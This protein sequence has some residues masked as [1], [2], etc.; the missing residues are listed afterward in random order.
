MR[1]RAKGQWRRSPPKKSPEVKPAPRAGL[2]ARQLAVRLVT[3]VIEDGRPLDQ[4]WSD[5]TRS[6]QFSALEPRDR[7]FARMLTATTL[8]RQGELEFVLKQFLERPLPDDKGHLWP[9]LLVGA[10]QLVCL[11]L[12]PHAVVDLGVELTRLDRGARRFAKLTNAV[13]RRVSEKGTALL[14][15][16]D[17]MHLNVPEWLLSRWEQTYGP[18]TARQIAQSS[19]REAPLDLSVKES[20][21]T[22]AWAERLGATALPMGSLRLAEHTGRIEDLPGYTEGAWWVQDAAAALVSRAAGAVAGLSVADLCAAP[23]GKTASLA[24]AGAHVTAVDASRTRLA[25]LEENMRRLGLSVEVVCADVAQWSPDREFDVVLLDA[26]CSATGTIRRHPDLMRQKQTQ[27]ITRLAQLQAAL[28]ARAATYV[29]PGGILLYSTCSLEPEEGPDQIEPFLA[30]HA[31]FRRDPLVAEQ[32]GADP[33]W[34]TPSGE[35]RTLPFH[36]PLEPKSL[37]GLDGFYVARL[38]RSG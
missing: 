4:A 3:A 7:A 21:S 35:L 6:V 36:L 20:Q 5:A 32:L 10:A 13:L 31:Q 19:L 37:S 2:G 27:D 12:P 9:I 29:R 11:K 1:E 17:A 14:E 28:L 18:A 22:Q 16:Q 15:A 33:A 23:G 34:I 8:R 38:R 30:T 26:P 24:S 25:R